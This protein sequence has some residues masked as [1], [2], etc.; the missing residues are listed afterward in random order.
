MVIIL[1]SIVDHRK[2]KA[3]L[4]ML[5]YLLLIAVLAETVLVYVFSASVARSH[6]RYAI[7]SAIIAVV[8]ALV[9]TVGVGAWLAFVQ[10]KYGLCIAL[11]LNVVAQLFILWVAFY[12]DDDDWFSD[13]FKAAKRKLKR[14]A[15][16]QKRRKFEPVRS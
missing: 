7:K 2:A 5:F 4:D 9:L 14:L 13:Q 10:Q 3:M 6:R 1:L 11:S 8:L 16:S 15:S 12:R